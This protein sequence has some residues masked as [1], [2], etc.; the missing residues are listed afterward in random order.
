MDEDMTAWAPQPGDVVRSTAGRDA[1]YA[2]VVVALE[3]RGVRLAD[4]R[5]RP[6]AK[7][8]RKNVR[9]VQF[10]GHRVTQVGIILPPDGQ[11]RDEDLRR[12]LHAWRE[13]TEGSDA[14]G[15]GR[16]D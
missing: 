11:W 13:V 10:T 14:G 9:H 16:H 1:G 15:E 2:F 7:P 3:P 4:G 8:K 5:Y 12:A 6:V